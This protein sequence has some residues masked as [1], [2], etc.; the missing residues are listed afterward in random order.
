[1]EGRKNSLC[2]FLV[3]PIGKILFL[4]YDGGRWYAVSDHTLCIRGLGIFDIG[5]Y[6]DGTA[7]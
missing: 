1:M 3:F 7:A 4:L 2:K 6:A 5:P